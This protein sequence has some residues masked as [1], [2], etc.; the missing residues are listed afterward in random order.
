MK[1][2]WLNWLFVLLILEA[3]FLLKEEFNLES[4]EEKVNDDGLNAVVKKNLNKNN[5]SD[6]YEFIL[7]SINLIKNIIIKWVM[8]LIE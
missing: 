7:P 2:N 1:I 8:I 5:N 6:K 4:L 3:I